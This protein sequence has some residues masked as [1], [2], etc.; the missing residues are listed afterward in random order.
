M[1]EL[2]N[3]FEELSKKYQGFIFGLQGVLF[4]GSMLLP[5]AVE[6]LEG[7]REAEK[8]VSLMSNTA[9]RSVALIEKLTSQG[10]PLSLYQHVITAGDE[11][12]RY[13]RDRSDPW[14]NA[15]GDR[16]FFIGSTEDHFLMEKLPYHSAPRVEEA[17]FILVAGRDEWD[18]NLEEYIPD[19]DRGLSLHQP[20]ICANPD[21]YTYWG[22]E[23][24]LCPGA[25]AAYY[26]AKGG[27]VYYHGKPY[28]SIFN[29]MLKKMAPL[30]REQILFIGDSLITDII[31]A[32]RMKFNTL[33][34]FSSVTQ[35]ELKLPSNVQ[36][37]LSLSEI[38]EMMSSQAAVPDYMMKTLKW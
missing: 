29:Q 1:P 35:E 11:A 4:N 7:L 20:L 25:F 33:L 10:L 26:K 3:R 18:K 17:D 5:G 27:E 16:C 34:V 31:G 9:Q 37:I 36:Q 13:L 24:V 15:L 30:P 23:R 14:H 38:S 19:L 21:L 22:K 28:I 8:M 32:S 2:W 12:Y 6:C